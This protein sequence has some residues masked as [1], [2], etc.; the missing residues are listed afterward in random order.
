MA[1]TCVCRLGQGRAQQRHYGFS[2]TFVWES[3]AI[4]PLALQPGSSFPLCM[5]LAP[6]KLLPALQL[7]MSGSFFILPVQSTQE[8]Y[9]EHLAQVVRE[10]AS[11][12]M[13]RHF[14][15]NAWDSNCPP[16]Y[17]AK[18]FAGFHSP[19]L[20]KLLFL[21]LQLCLG[22]YMSGWDPLLRRWIFTAEIA[23]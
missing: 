13:H 10:L 22:R 6:F 19:K 23:F 5:F 4:S 2:S 17:S 20:L 9:L 14:R 3:A 18:V 21:A 8:T 1:H 12:S 7:R 16:S 11:K 15:R